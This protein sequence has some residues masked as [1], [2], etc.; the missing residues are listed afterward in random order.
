VNKAT[1]L[2]Q[3]ISAL[4]EAILNLQQA[5]ESQ[6]ALRILQT[7]LAKAPSNPMVHLLLGLAYRD[8]A[9]L[10]KAEASLRQA[11]KLDPDQVEAEQAL[12]LVLMGQGKHEEAATVLERHAGKRLT[13][14][15]TLRA[16]G[17]AW[18]WTGQADKAAALLQ[19]RWETSR[20]FEVGVVWGRLLIRL[21]DLD[22]A[23]AAFQE[24]AEQFPDHPRPLA[25]IGYI[26]TLQER[27]AD[28]LAT[29]QA[30]TATF[31]DYDR[32]WRSLSGIYFSQGDYL[33]ALDAAEHALAIDAQHYRNWLAKSQALEGLLKIQDALDAAQAGIACGVSDDVDADHI[34]ISLRLAES[35]CLLNLNRTEEGVTALDRLRSDFPKVI[36]LVYF[37]YQV[38]A[39]L[40]RYQEALDTLDRAV[41][42]GIP[43][44]RVLA[45]MRYAILH[46]LGR[47]KDAWAFVHPLLDDQTEQRL[48]V[49]GNVAVS[50]Y[51]EGRIEL[52][53]TVLEQLLGFAPENARILSNLAFLLIGEGDL[54]SAK[55]YLTRSLGSA[56]EDSHQRPLSLAN[57][58]YLHLLQGEFTQAKKEL[59]DVIAIAHP[60]MEAVQRI[61]YWW[62]GQID[63]GYTPHPDR[64]LPVGMAARANLSTCL[65][66]QGHAGAAETQ[67][68]QLIEQ[69]PNLSVGHECLGW[70]LLAQADVAGTRQSWQTALPLTQ[71][72]AL[73][74]AIQGWLTATG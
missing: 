62:N 74:A 65:L 47:P 72:E 68:R 56:D 44:D 38:L 27:Q 6:Q 23:K 59:E 2:D 34:L 50:F 17:K 4:I 43:D 66:A 48:G 61:A 57:L 10:P 70:A 58:A 14:P 52:A 54:S 60:A 40:E 1:P 22:A 63:P 67:A 13:D 19:S 42:A 21:R 73:A 35:R 20:D 53:R 30:L 45:P 49:L 16:L 37:E 31:P 18:Q 71:S 5:G 28:A 32:G 7:A 33:Q 69:A 9:E 64:Y 51:Q 12:G 15:V 11:L 26:L 25:E 46:R 3:Q 29:Y 8:Q 39:H 36:E 41:D 24:V 55:E